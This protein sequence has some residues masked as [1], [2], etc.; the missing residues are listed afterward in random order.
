MMRQF[1]RRLAEA[2]VPAFR[3]PETA[4]DAFSQLARFHYN[5]QLLLQA[6]PPSPPLLPADLDEARRIIAA[7]RAR[8][9]LHLSAPEC[10]RLLAAFGV[11]T[12]D[13][14]AHRPPSPDAHALRIR[15]LRD[16][17][18]G[19]V[20]TLGVAD[21]WPTDSSA[22]VEL[23]PLNAFLARS[24]MERSSAWTRGCLRNAAS[25]ALEQLEQLLIALT[26]IVVALPDVYR[27]EI[28]PVYVEDTAVRLSSSQVILT[29]PGDANLPHLAIAP[30][31]V[32][33]VQEREFPDGT[34]WTLRP[35][36]PEDAE[37]LQNFVRGLSSQTRY[38]RFVSAMREL[39]PRMLARYTQIDYFRELAL[40]ATVLEPNPEHRGHPREVI[41][42]LAHYLLNPDGAGA[43]YALV[44]SD[45]YQRRGLG[46][47]LMQALV[48]AAREQGLHYL[49]GHVLATNRPMLTLMTGLGFRQEP[50]PDD[51]T[52]RRVWIAL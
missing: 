43:E 48:K 7:A 9:E 41:V 51:H 42:G 38:M 1:R 32:A 25:P 30:Y 50:I 39:P 8:A 49:E 5:Q 16:R 40:I 52:M 26:E 22:G 27:L 2:G 33:W 34:P 19:A 21:E 14:F 20:V 4:V 46:K 18:F 29:G 35:I 15:I 31:P 44:V 23:L 10:R 12:Q 36:R 45:R 3:T 24:L 17:L 28:N 37:P 11:A 6:Q 13:V 47:A